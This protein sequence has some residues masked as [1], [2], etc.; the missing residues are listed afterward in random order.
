MKGEYKIGLKIH[1]SVMNRHHGC[2]WRHIKSLLRATNC[3]VKKYSKSNY[4][5]LS[6][7]S[8]I[9]FF[10]VTHSI[11][12]LDFNITLKYELIRKLNNCCH[13]WCRH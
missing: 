2:K 1:S 5:V 3:E 4:E 10:R 9:F 7:C 13:T 6:T 11:S 12:M 8:H